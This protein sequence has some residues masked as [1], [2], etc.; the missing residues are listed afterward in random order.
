LKIL[1]AGA[2]GLLGSHLVALLSGSGHEV[3]GVR[4]ERPPQLKLNGVKYV[5]AD[6]RIRS[7]CESVTRD[8]DIVFLCAAVTG[9]V[10]VSRN[11]TSPVLDTLQINANLLDV[12]AKQAVKRVVVASSTT[13]YPSGNVPFAECDG[14][15]GEPCSEYYGIGWT[16][17]YIEKLALYYSNVFGLDINIARLAS[18]YGPFDDFSSERSH[19][20]PSLIKRFIRAEDTVYIWGDSGQLRD[21]LFAGDAAVVMQ[22]LAFTGRC[23]LTVNVGSGVMTS[24]GDLAFKI[25]SIT[26]R[27]KVK[28]I[29]NHD[30]PSGP[31]VRAI[32]TTLSKDIFG[33]LQFRSIDD[34]LAETAAWFEKNEGRGKDGF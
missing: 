26:G 22:N 19:V 5:Q 11:L 18:L 9:G 25:A 3:I 12:A 27:L 23:G 16:N 32:D 21:F 13:V 6:L 7:E 4:H 31:K 34:G 8:T 10:S 15:T 24:I 1:V 17:R 20:I 2:T 29:F 28:I 30:K 14:F 33:A